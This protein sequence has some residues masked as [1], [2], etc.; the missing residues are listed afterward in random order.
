MPLRFRSL[1]LA[2]EELKE[3]GDRASNLGAS[4]IVTNG[5]ADVNGTT[6]TITNDYTDMGFMFE[7]R[8][9]PLAGQPASIVINNIQAS[10][11]NFRFR[12]AD[13]SF[14][15]DPDGVQPPPPPTL[16]TA[17]G[18]NLRPDATFF[19]Y[20]FQGMENQD[21]DLQFSYQRSLAPEPRFEITEFSYDP[22]TAQASVTWTS[23]PGETYIIHLTE[24][25]EGS[26]GDI[27]DDFEAN[28]VGDTTTEVFTVPGPV[29]PNLFVF[30]ELIVVEP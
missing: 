22:D 12:E 9:V 17:S 1:R 7:K 5:I 25:L 24:S 4:N 11:G 18:L 23:V 30:V 14:S 8:E 27:G 21:F 2:E 29:P 6:V 19:V 15:Y 26:E 28:A 13:F 16:L 10:D 20:P 3:L